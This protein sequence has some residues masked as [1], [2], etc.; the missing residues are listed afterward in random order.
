MSIA[1]LKTAATLLLIKINVITGWALYE[2]PKSAQIL[3]E[4]FEL[5]IKESYPNVNVDEM[6]YA[7]RQNT[8]VKDWGKFM[9]L[10]LIDEV[11]IPYLNQRKEISDIEERR[12]P[13]TSP[14]TQ[15]VISSWRESIQ[16]ALN[17]F[18]KGNYEYRLWVSDMYDQ[19]VY[20]DFIPALY[21]KSFIDAARLFF[22]NKLQIEII[23]VE[24]KII[25]NPKYLSDHKI[26]EN[27]LIE[28]RNGTRDKEVILLS[29]QKAI[30]KY[31]EYL[32]GK[33]ILKIYE[34]T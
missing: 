27:R 12:T 5:K 21:Y 8:T 32:K 25:H 22:C 10:G 33:N 23:Q 3:K 16:I 29:K 7:F 26:L 13:P 34:Q 14:N 20:D 9:N 2:D 1:E 11:M 18:Y 15:S 31:F 30:L 28:Y 19:L 17:K 6:E 24:A 4:Q